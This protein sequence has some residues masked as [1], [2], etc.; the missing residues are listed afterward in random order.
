M[1]NNPRQRNIIILGSAYPLRG[2]GIATYNERLARAYQQNGDQATIITF[3]LQYPKFLFPGT[4]QYSTEAPPVDL[5]IEVLVN[6]INPLNWIKV[7]R[8]IKKRRPDLLVLRYWIPFMGPCLGTISRIVKRNR[9]SRIVAIVDNYI[10]HERRPGD[11]LFSKYF[12]K[13]IHGFVTMSRQVLSDLA[14]ADNKKPRRYCPHPLY[15]NFGALQTKAI[16][17][18]RLKL[19]ADGRYLLFFG[20]I[21]DYKGLDLLLE[22]MAL[23]EVI[24]T[25]ARLIVAGEFY[26]EAKPYHDIIRKHQLEPRVIL[27]TEFIPNE[28]VADYFNAA[29]LVVQPYKDATQSGVTQVAYHFEKPMI[30]TNVGGLSE[31]VPDGITGFVVEPDVKDIAQAIARFFEENKEAEFVANLKI[32]KLKFSWERMLEAID[33]VAAAEARNG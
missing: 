15:D 19:P 23:P 33:E 16:A 32:E 31:M 24:R 7:G 30:T 13:P 14:K 3:S 17:R 22:A 18:E 20:F 1:K 11:K 10:P 12:I 21:R 6:S 2:G 5:H 25:N 29:D 4:T 26:A 8:L 28:V 27:A 9:H